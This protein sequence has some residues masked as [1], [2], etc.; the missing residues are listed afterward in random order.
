MTWMDGEWRDDF[1]VDDDD[2]DVE[3]GVGTEEEDAGLPLLWRLFCLLVVSWGRRQAT[4]AHSLGFIEYRT[5][6]PPS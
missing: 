2:D 1:S 5:T 4:S 6:R 3:G